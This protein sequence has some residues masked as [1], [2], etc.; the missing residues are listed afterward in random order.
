MARLVT[1][2]THNTRN[3]PVQNVHDE[4]DKFLH[5]VFEG[6]G[7]M[8]QMMRRDNTTLNVSMDMWEDDKAY[9]LQADMPGVEDKDVDITLEE[10]TLRI[11]A[12][13]KST[14]E[15]Q[16]KNYHRVERAYG[17]FERQLTLPKNVNTDKVD[18]KL[19]N[20]V[21]T[22]TL[23]KKADDASKTKKVKLTS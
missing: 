19:K 13:K 1:P 20:G 17:T 5:D 8:P 3:M 21:L 15:E 14:Q 23:P 18:A 16:E 22:V 10:D 9:M 4:L 12:E 2:F 7:H 6:F 11:K